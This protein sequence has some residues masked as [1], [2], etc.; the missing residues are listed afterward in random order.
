[1]FKAIQKSILV[2]A[3]LLSGLAHTEISFADDKSDEMGIVK[4]V[5]ADLPQAI[6]GLK[7]SVNINSGTMNFDGVRAV[8]D[9]YITQLTALG[10][11][12]KF[13]D[14]SGFGRAGHVVARRNGNSSKAT[15]ILM[16]GHLDTVF[17]KGDDFQGWK[18]LGDNKVMGPGITDMKG[19]NI[20][21]IAA[22]RALK[23]QGL[24]DDVSIEVVM[25]GDEERSGAPLAASKKALVDAA[26]WADIALGFED[27]DGSI[28]TAVVSRRGSI[29][30]TLDVTG[31]P[32]HSSQVFRKDYGYGA[33]YE[34]ARILNQFRVQLSSV[35]NLTFNPGMIIGG[36]RIHY[37]PFDAAGDA[38]GKSNVISQTVKVTGDIRALSP[39]QLADAKNVMQS[40]VSNNLNLTTASLEFNEGYPPLSPSEANYKLL[41]IY[42]QVSEDLGFGSV[43]PVD[44]RKAGAA[45]ISFTEGH[46]DMAMDGLG[47]MGTGGHT[48]NE[49]ADMT[50]LDKNIKK[51]AVLIYRLSKK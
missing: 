28:K 23:K 14:G 12:A 15:K 18:E 32:A 25:T 44:P 42:S 29:G 40:I 48:K 36:T 5:D 31:R 27:G 21:M 3:I 17:A 50:S 30:W 34:A 20:I 1:M 37:K 7:A 11:D 51:A 49:T 13:V 46:V 35:E 2:S 19:G 6:S 39:K 9:Q 26:I 10:F 38:F 41:G 33:I 47:L 16:I 43:A 22:L 24:L 4:A 8:G 45:D